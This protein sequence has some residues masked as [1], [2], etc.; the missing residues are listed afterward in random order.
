MSTVAQTIKPG[1]IIV[2]Q[3]G[4]GLS[5]L[6]N[7]KKFGMKNKFSRNNQAFSP[8][9]VILVNKNSVHKIL[10]TQKYK[11]PSKAARAYD[12]VKYLWK[13]RKI[14]VETLWNQ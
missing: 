1:R 13:N 2:R 10:F 11:I 14:P 8:I 4:V 3:E 9:F 12:L 5:M 7:V 6:R